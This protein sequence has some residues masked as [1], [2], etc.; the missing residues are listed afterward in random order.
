MFYRPN[1]SY[2]RSILLFLLILTIVVSG[3]SKSNESEPIP[4]APIDVEQPTPSSSESQSETSLTP[5]PSEE[6]DDLTKLIDNLTL[7][8]K[9]GQLILIGVEGTAIDDTLTK[10]IQDKHYGGIIFYQN[11]LSNLADSVKLINE[12]KAA[13]SSNPLPLFLSVDQEG[14]KVSRLPSDFVTMPSAATVGRTEN[15]ELASQM[16]KILAEELKLMGFNVNFAPVLDIA[17]NPN[18]KVI[19]DR[20]FGDQADLVTKMGIAQMKGMQD[21]GVIPVIKHFPGHGD[22]ST[23]SHLN[24]PI[25]NKTID[26]LK[27][28]EWIPFQAAIKE[29]AEVV[30]IA[31]ILYPNIDKDAPAS[32]SH[33]LIQDQLRG[34]LGFEGVVITD[35]LTMGAISNHYGVVP[36][37]INAIKA[38]S[39]I[40]MIAHNYKQMNLVY[41]QLL[42]EVKNGNITEERINESVRRIITL[43]QKYNLTNEP[44]P[45][46]S[47]ND[48]PNAAIKEW[49]DKL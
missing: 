33:I 29:Q 31:H 48:L 25:V 14:G 1:R 47:L 4:P 13:N 26:E 28:L 43:K 38:G 35:E 45:I 9:I 24:L 6:V 22:T 23:D 19:G 36:S 17:S 40:V 12:L 5:A 3:C 27:Q 44:T 16:G 39:D 8:E 30:M 34:K 18:N 37:A 46:P 41:K 11:N 2:R 20:A 49:L 7:E 21:N 10:M 32:F 42:T 15:P